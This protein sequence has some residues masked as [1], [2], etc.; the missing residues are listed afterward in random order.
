MQTLQHEGDEGSGASSPVEAEGLHQDSYRV[1]EVH[2]SGWTQ[3]VGR[4][5]SIKREKKI[6]G[7]IEF[8]RLEVKDLFLSHAAGLFLLQGASFKQLLDGTLIVEQQG[9]FLEAFEATLVFAELPAL[10]RPPLVIRKAV[11]AFPRRFPAG[12]SSSELSK[13]LLLLELGGT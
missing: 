7:E 9:T 11:F 3:P 12:L 4:G 8:E 1:I 10:H 5:L 13:A 2:R 6:S